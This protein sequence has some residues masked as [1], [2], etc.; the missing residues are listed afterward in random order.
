[1]I[2]TWALVHTYPFE[3]LLSVHSGG[4]GVTKRYVNS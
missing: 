1:M 2:L 3:M 4:L